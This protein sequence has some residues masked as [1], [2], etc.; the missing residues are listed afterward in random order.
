MIADQYD[1]AV[2]VAAVDYIVFADDHFAVHVA[3]VIEIGVLCDV[4]VAAVD[5][6]AVAISVVGFITAALI[7]LL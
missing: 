6:F 5:N 7:I 1:L 3:I 4:V 2:P